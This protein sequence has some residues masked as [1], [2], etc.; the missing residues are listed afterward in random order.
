MLS[1]LESDARVQ[2]QI[3]DNDL[4]SQLDPRDPLIILSEA[5]DWSRFEAEF[6]RYYSPAQGRPG[7]SSDGRGLEILDQRESFKLNNLT[8]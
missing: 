5:I 2:S 6:S 8:I 3:F 1:K 4:P 7:F